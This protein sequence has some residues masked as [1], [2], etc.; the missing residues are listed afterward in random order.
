MAPKTIISSEELGKR[1]RARRN[2]LN[3]TIEEAALRAGVGIKTWCRYESGGSIRLDKRLGVCKALNW[4]SFPTDACDESSNDED[5]VAEYRDHEA[6]SSFLEKKYGLQAAISF[7]AGSDILLDYINQDLSDLSSMPAGTHIG[8]L[9]SSF[10]KAELPPQF[11]MRYTYDF[12]YQMKS[13]LIQLRGQAAANTS[14]IAHTVMQELLI[15]LCDQEAQ[16]LMEAMDFDIDEYDGSS[17]W[18][19]NLFDDSDILLLYSNMLLDEDHV[20]HFTHWNEP[21]FFLDSNR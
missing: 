7:A 5:F 10:L 16:F 1:I 3:L 2:E 6:W 20:Y 4:R 21:Q 17:D 14:M 12:L 11:L 15:Y 13:T 19:F 8:Q 9:G 18:V